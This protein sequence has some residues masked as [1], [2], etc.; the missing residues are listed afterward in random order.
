VYEAAV[1]FVGGML[2]VSASSL[3]SR[4]RA[5]IA[6]GTVTIGIAASAVSGELGISWAYALID[7]AQVGAGAVGGVCL[8][9]ARRWWASA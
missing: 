6:G 4:A 7:I 8:A 9:A 1:V 5:A 2:G 3:R